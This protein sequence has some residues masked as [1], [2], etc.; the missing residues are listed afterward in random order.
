MRVLNPVVNESWSRDELVEQLIAQ[1]DA[2][3]PDAAYSTMESVD[4]I[5][6][7]FR[8]NEHDSPDLIHFHHY[9]CFVIVADGTHSLLQMNYETWKRGCN[10]EEVQCGIQL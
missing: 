4:I 9:P 3:K 10:V 8:A 2:T 5:V 6:S 1:L 7:W